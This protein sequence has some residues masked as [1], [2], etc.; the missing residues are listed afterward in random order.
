MTSQRMSLHGVL[1]QLLH[2]T[3]CVSF[4]EALGVVQ[5]ARKHDS[6]D[7]D[8]V[9][10]LLQLHDAAHTTDGARTILA[11]FL[12]G[13]QTRV[14][15]QRFL[16]ARPVTLKDHGKVTRVAPGATLVLLLDER[17]AAGFT[18]DVSAVSGKPQW[19]R[20]PNPPET[21]TKACFEFTWERTGQRYLTLR[22]EC[23]DPT[24]G[25]ADPGQ[26]ARTFELRIIVENEG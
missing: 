17:R 23:T 4:Y 2:A 21:V 26:K 15:Q 8:V 18:W 5:D 12:R 25:A 10:L 19:T 7:A 11:D 3:D 6:L 20:L 14:Q 13:Y 16:G 9:Q 1:P 22:E 24:R